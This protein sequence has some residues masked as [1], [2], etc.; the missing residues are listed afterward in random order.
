MAACWLAK[1]ATLV[2]SRLDLERPCLKGK[3]GRMIGEGAQPQ[4]FTAWTHLHG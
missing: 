1:L 4:A 3:G 2:S